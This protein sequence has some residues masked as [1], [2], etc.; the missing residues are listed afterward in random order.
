MATAGDF[1][2]EA[3]AWIGT[4]FHWQASVKGVGCDCKGLVAGVARALGLPEAEGLYARM[5]DYGADGRVPVS[6]LLR[7]MAETLTRTPVAR[8]GDVLLF[9]MSGQPQHMGVHAGDHV[10]HTY[11]GGPRRVIATRL[12]LPARPWPLHSAW[13]FPSL[14][15]AA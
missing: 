1:V 15:E 7:G 12:A 9:R 10:I 4:P 2:A 6:T 14:E 3:Q 11:N 8:P 5:A 13:R